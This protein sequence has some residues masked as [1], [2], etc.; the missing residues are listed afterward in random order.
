MTVDDKL[1]NVLATGALHALLSM[2]TNPVDPEHRALVD[3]ELVMVDGQATNQLEVR[4]SFLISP[5]LITVERV[6]DDD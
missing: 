3:V 2:T 1:N 4:F 6:E 5:Y